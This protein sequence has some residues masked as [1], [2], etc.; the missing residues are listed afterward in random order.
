MEEETFDEQPLLAIK[1]ENELS[2]LGESSGVGEEDED[3]EGDVGDDEDD[4]DDNV[5]DEE[6]NHGMFIN[7]EHQYIESLNQEQQAS[8]HEVIEE[9]EIEA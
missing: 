8:H 1:E 5:E 6:Q 4:D 2:T 3:D 7:E 9:S